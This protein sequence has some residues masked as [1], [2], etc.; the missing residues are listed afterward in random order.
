[1]ARASSLPPLRGQGPVVAALTIIAAV[2]VVDILIAADRVA[3][4]S[5]MI[6]APLLCGITVSPAATLRVGLLSVLAAALAFIWGPSPATSRY[7]IPLG[8]VAVGSAFAVA[9]ARYR[10]KAERDAWRMR[11]LAEVAEIAYGGERV[12]EIARAVVDVLVPRL[13]DLCTID[14][15]GPGGA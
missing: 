14:I 12:E 10:G 1:M 2:V 11:V 13:V 4:T 6:A 15:V 7:W 9:M 8:V 3:V 5:L